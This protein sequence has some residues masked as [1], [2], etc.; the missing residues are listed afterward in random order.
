MTDQGENDFYSHTWVGKRDKC[1]Q[2]PVECTVE[3]HREPKTRT[4]LLIYF[5][6]AKNKPFSSTEQHGPLLS[7]SRQSLMNYLR[8]QQSAGLSRLSGASNWYSFDSDRAEPC[9]IALCAVGRT[10]STGARLCGSNWMHIL[11]LAPMFMCQGT[12][13][14][15]DDC[16]LKYLSIKEQGDYNIGLFNVSTE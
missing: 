16:R 7:Y 6:L 9:D 14:Y 2:Q 4:A 1:I 15:L 8:N 10:S 13:R 5:L 12:L 3:K 11:S